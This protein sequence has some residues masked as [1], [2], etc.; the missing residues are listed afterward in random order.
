M[1]MVTF[2]GRPA[3]AELTGRARALA[4]RPEDRVSRVR[5]R[6]EGRWYEC[7]HCDDSHEIWLISWLRGR[8][9]GFHDHAAPRARSRWRSAAWKSMTSSATAWS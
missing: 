8:A 1:T 6:A 2:A 7:V 3:V 9:T 4:A 5:L